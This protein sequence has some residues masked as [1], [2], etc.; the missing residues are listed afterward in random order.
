MLADSGKVLSVGDKGL[1][2]DP[3]RFLSV[4]K[5]GERVR[6]CDAVLHLDFSHFSTLLICQISL[7][8]QARCTANQ[9][10]E[11]SKS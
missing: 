5:V 9:E 6:H 3:R 8:N 4:E 1:F 11:K 2:A 7:K 10:C